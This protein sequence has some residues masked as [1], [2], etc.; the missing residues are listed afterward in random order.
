MTPAEF[1]V[2]Y[3]EFN[4]ETD[5]RVQLF[6]DE[7]IPH[8]DEARWD[9]LYVQG[10]GLYVAHSLALANADVGVDV[11]NDTNVKVGDVSISKDATIVKAQMENEFLRTTYGQ[12]YAR[13]A[14][15]VGGGGVAT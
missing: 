7:A 12:R 6:L 4:T 15:L 11:G 13:V 10:L 14:R 8:L 9:D 2:R 5:Q 3:P 1:K